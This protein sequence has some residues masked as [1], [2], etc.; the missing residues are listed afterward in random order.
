MGWPPPRGRRSRREWLSAALVLLGL[1]AFVALTYGVVVVGLGRLT[2][3][4]GQPSLALSVVATAVVAL[5]FDPVLSRLE[6]SARRVVDRGRPEPYDTLRRF[7]GDVTVGEATEGLPLRMAR[8]LAEATGAAWVQVRVAVEGQQLVAATW[9]AEAEVGST[10]GVEAGTRQLPVRHGDEELGVILLQERAGV[11]LTPVEERLFA[12][13]A[14]QAGLVLRGARLRAA[15]EQR[16]AELS[17]REAQLRES[18]ERLVDAQDDARRRL[19]RDIHDGAQQHLVALAVNLRL[20]GTLAVSAP[21]RAVELLTAQERA[22]AEAEATLDRLARGIYPPLLEGAGVAAALR[23]AIADPAVDLEAH[24]DARYRT[25]TEA[26]A[27]FCVLEALQNAR[28]HAGARRTRVE[29][30]ASS[31]EAL[32]VSVSDDGRGFDPALIGSPGGL[33]LSN[34]RDR[35]ESAGGTLEVLTAPRG[36]TCVRAVLAAREPATRGG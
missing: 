7:T 8:L 24:G 14:S 1:V 20:A 6:R 21:E 29:V 11:P 25:E 3:D 35:V 4:T 26:A 28:K 36:G 34:M 5:G 12:G 16:L 33:G 30:D 18:R 9:P 2:G 10:P 31:P 19:E 17:V 27:Y 32:T 13:I 15:L 23:G 22:A